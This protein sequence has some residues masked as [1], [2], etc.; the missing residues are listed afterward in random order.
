M[1]KRLEL[2][3][4]LVPQAGVIGLLVNQNSPFAERIIGDVQEA[5]RAKG[6]QLQILKAGVEGEFETAFASLAQS[7]AG[8]LL[9]GNDPFF[10]SRRDQ[11]VAL[12]ARYAVP[13]IY[14]WREFTV[15]G[16]GGAWLSPGK[17]AILL[18][19]VPRRMSA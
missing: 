2:L 9:V 6:V 19:P 16:F 18:A 3:S 15:V 1:P 14:E 4:E 10:F 5:A 7:R 17:N 8:A 13:A 11:L 12:A